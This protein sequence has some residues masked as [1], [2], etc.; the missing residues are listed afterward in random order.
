[1]A[2]SLSSMVLKGI[3]VSRSSRTVC[4]SFYHNGM[5][6]STTVPSDSDTHEDFRPTNKLESSP[7]SLKDVV[8]QDVKENPVMI[9]MKGVPEFPQCGFSSLAVR[10]LKQYNVP[11]SARNIL[12][13]PELKGAVKSFSNWPTFPQI[14]IKGEFIGGSD[15]ILNMHQTG[16]LKEKVKDIAANQEK[17]E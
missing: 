16:E 1:M 7:L 9:Y 3:A 15:I 8:E 14:F 4:G 5:R 13:N 17:S 2:R 11:L 12:E 10:V 6:Y